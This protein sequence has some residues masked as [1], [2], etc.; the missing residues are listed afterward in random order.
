MGIIGNIIV[1][2]PV[3]ISEDHAGIEQFLKRFLGMHEP[4]IVED[5]VPKT[6]IEKM[7]HSMLGTSDVQ[8]HRHPIVLGFCRPRFFMVSW[9]TKAQVIP[10]ASQPTEASYSHLATLF[11]LVS[12]SMTSTQ[13]R[14][15]AKGG[16]N[17]P[18]GRKSSSSGSNTGRSASGTSFV[19]P[20]SR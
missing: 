17:S 19:V 20:S 18:E 14:T 5:F 9:I 12:G 6:G 3:T 2:I 8:I 7:Q 1:V 11:V 4:E 15:R 16:S 13:S 10:A